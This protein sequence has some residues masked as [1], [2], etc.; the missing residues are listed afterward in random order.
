MPNKLDFNVVKSNIEKKGY[1]LISK[2]YKNSTSLLEVVC[3]NGHNIKKTYNRLKF[4]NCSVCSGK[5]KWD[6][7]DVEQLFTNNNCK[8]ISTYY[9]NNSSKLDYLC[10]KNH[11]GSITIKDFLFGYDC[12]K[13]SYI[14]RAQKQILTYEE[15]K[16]R[17]E[18]HSF[19]LISEK[20]ENSKSPLIVRC[21]K[22]HTI[23]TD[24]SRFTNGIRC[25]NCS[26]TTRAEKQSLPHEEVKIR[27]EDCNYTLLSEY[28]NNRSV[29]EIMCDY[30]HI[31]ETD[32]DRFTNGV[33]CKYCKHKNEQKCREVL[34]LFLN[35]KFKKCRPKWLGGLELDGFNEELNLAFEYNG[36]QHY[37]ENHFFHRKGG[38]YHSLKER[39]ERKKS[40]CENKEIILYIIPY[41]V[42]FEDLESYIYELISDTKIRN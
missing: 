31:Y 12:N 3:P 27:F 2:V 37:Q 21:P 1:K 5:K 23:R 32:I 4:S 9:V 14:K 42:K 28:K 38:D 16:T 17:F 19:S 24:I 25:K 30:G 22:G 36:R 26:M 35:V 34:E 15:V 7:K 40:L 41:T 39:D 11:K 20:Y 13:C 6:Y 8:L 18:N 33:R 10:P 29:L